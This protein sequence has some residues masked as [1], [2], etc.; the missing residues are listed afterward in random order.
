MTDKE[1]LDYLIEAMRD[2]AQ[3]IDNEKP[4]VALWE[5]RRAVNTIEEWD[6]NGA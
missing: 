1:K 2:I 4:D 5:I 6:G 3:A